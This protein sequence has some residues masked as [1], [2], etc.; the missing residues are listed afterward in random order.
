MIELD[1]VTINK[2]VQINAHIFKIYI[3]NPYHI[4]AYDARCTFQRGVQT[5]QC[6]RYYFG[7]VLTVYKPKIE[8]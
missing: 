6:N 3:L 1:I 8:K 7:Q 5:Q 4:I 2:N